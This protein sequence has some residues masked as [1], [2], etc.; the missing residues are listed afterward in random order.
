MIDAR[1]APD[2]GAHLARDGLG[3]LLELD[4][5]A[6][7]LADRVEEVDL[8]VA[9]GQLFGQK[10]ALPLGVEQRA[11]D[12]QQAGRRRLERRLRQPADLEPEALDLVDRLEP[13]AAVGRGRQTRRPRHLGRGAGIGAGGQSQRAAVVAPQAHPSPDERAEAVDDEIEPP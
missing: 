9:A 5:L 2:H 6:Q 12:R 8:L 13:D 3:G 11:D 4:G 10:R 7:D 1:R